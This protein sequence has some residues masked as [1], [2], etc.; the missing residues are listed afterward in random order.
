MRGTPDYVDLNS[1]PILNRPQ[2]LTA[3]AIHCSHFGIL[4][5]HFESPVGLKQCPH[6]RHRCGYCLDRPRQ[7]QGRPTPGNIQFT[8]CL[9][10]QSPNCRKVRSI[11]DI[12]CIP[13][14]QLHHSL[15]LT[16]SSIVTHGQGILHL[17][18]LSSDLQRSRL[19]ICINLDTSRL[20]RGLD[21]RPALP[22]DGLD[23]ITAP[24][25]LF[26]GFV[27]FTL[28]FSGKNGTSLEQSPFDGFL[29][30]G[31]GEH[32]GGAIKVEFGSGIF[33]EGLDGRSSLSDEDERIGSSWDGG[34][35]FTL[36]GG[37]GSS[38]EL[39]PIAAASS[40]FSPSVVGPA[41]A[42]DEDPLGFFFFA[43]S[44]AAAALAA[45]SASACALAASSAAFLSSSAFLASSS[46][47]FFRAL[48][49]SL[50]LLAAARLVA[51][52]AFLFRF[53]ADWM[54]HRS[55][56]S[57]ASSSESSSALASS[58]NVTPLGESDDVWLP[59]APEDFFLAFFFFFLDPSPES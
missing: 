12:H 50:S 7:L 19:H 57:S 33:L 32:V 59:E 23:G 14:T 47:C 30:S 17:L 25:D 11:D 37:D 10:L 28:C 41:E 22:D 26:C 34:G 45:A 38:L 55:M 15:S 36:F 16:K 20:L 1:R 5:D 44:K 46:S 4:N 24:S 58:W 13:G 2:G 18:P 39:F 48:S 29:C 53:D 9:I 51:S 21:I 49:L 8:S 6:P 27:R 43:S 42:A 40:S 35:N 56:S 54:R 3:L 31:D 52:L